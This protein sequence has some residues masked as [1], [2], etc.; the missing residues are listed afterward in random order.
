MRDK[1]KVGYARMSTM[2]QNLGQ[3]L[4]VLENVVADESHFKKISGKNTTNCE[5]F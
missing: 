3:Q 1:M 2:D 4:E 5:E